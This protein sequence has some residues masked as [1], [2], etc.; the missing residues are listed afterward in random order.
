MS[1]TAPSRADPVVVFPLGRWCPPQETSQPHP[2]RFIQEK[3][4]EMLS[5]NWWPFWINFGNFSKSN[6][7]PFL[8][9]IL[10]RMHI[11][12]QIKPIL[13]KPTDNDPNLLISEG[14][15]STSACHIL[16]QSFHVFPRKC[17]ESL[18][19]QYIGMS[20]FSIFQ[21]FSRECLET[22]NLTHFTK[23]KLCQN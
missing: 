14:G 22:P 3:V 9:C 12:V 8:L 10:Q 13:G 1:N 15:Q 19:S 2:P 6:F 21:A 16:V 17:P 18:I 7:R 20:N 23:S 5:A 4:P 11:E